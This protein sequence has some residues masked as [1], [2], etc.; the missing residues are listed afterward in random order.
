MGLQAMFSSISGLQ[1]DSQWLDVIGNN[2]SNVNTVAYK[3]SRAEFAD[4]LSQTLLGGSGDNPSN[5]Q[6][7]VDPEQVGLGTRLAS[8]ET[9][10]TQGATINTG[11]STDI[12]IQGNGF[13]VANQGD[14]S[15]LTRAG[16]LTFDS[17]GYLVNSNGDRIQG[18]NATLQYVHTTINS[19]ANGGFAQ[20]T[21]A[22]LELNSNSIS[23]TQSIQINPEMTLLPKAT[24]EV[25]F[26]GNLDAFQQPNVLDLFPGGFF[27]G[28]SLPIG[29][30]IAAIGP[31]NAI[32]PARMTVQPTATG[33]FALQQL[34]DLSDFTPGLNIPPPPLE[35]G[36]INL[37]FA[38]AFAGSYVWDQQ[39]PVPPADQMAETVYD[40]NGNAR[41]ITVQFYQVNDLGADGINNPN[42]PNQVCYAWYA[43]DT[44]GGQ[45]VSTA[46]LLGG[47]GIGEGDFNSP[48]NPFFS[49][50]RGL[51]GQNFFGDFLW[52]NT[53]GSLASSGGVG[54][55]PGPPGLNFN[56]MAVPRVYLPPVNSNP[57]VSPIPTQGAEIT[58][59]SLNFGNFGL[60]GIGERNGVYSDADGSYKIINGVNTYVPDS[61]V[62]PASQDG[63]PEGQLQ[64][65]SFDPT[66]VIEG[67]FSNGQTVGLAQVALEQVQNPDGLSQ[68]GNN[69]YTL[70]PNAGPSQVGQAGQG[71]FGT[72]QDDSLE[73]SN[74]DLTTELSNM[75]LAQRS[76]DTDSRMIAVVNE[77]MDTLDN[78]GE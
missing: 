66:G 45:P 39:P 49:Y 15:Y 50:D 27:G 68:T 65:I 73:G 43:F 57:P 20:V 21:S 32:D 8:I 72:I 59:I 77:M 52:F 22:Q 48:V 61:T 25:T 6:G 41:Q 55:V 1:S 30:T 9:I 5:G 76:F 14:Q 23:N 4:Q 69:D 35:N 36:F 78:L 63:Y 71:N 62:Y 58:P 60:L 56:Y 17:Q 10:F 67:A 7:G 47:T 70:S 64:G 40:S 2:I 16:N 51:A 74:V 46:D 29:L 11:I 13:L 38:K 33:G 44:T 75:I 54:G 37:D 34:E 19:A 12:S 42:G 31:P 28:P 24:T 18:I 3:A 26:K 53:D